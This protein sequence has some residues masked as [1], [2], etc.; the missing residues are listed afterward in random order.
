MKVTIKMQNYLV[1]LLSFLLFLSLTACL[2]A[3]PQGD[4]QVIGNQTSRTGTVTI[5]A[6]LTGSI[7]Y[8]EIIYFSGT[9]ESIPNDSFLLRLTLPD[10]STLVE[11]PVTISNGSWSA[12][13]TH[14]Y[15]GEPTQILIYALPVDATDTS[16]DYALESLV[17]A[18]EEYRPEGVFAALLSPS[19]DAVVG[20]DELEIIGTA[21]GLFENTLLIRLE[22]RDGTLISET[23]I[24]VTNPNFIDE[25]LWSADLPTNDFT[26]L[27]RVRLVITDAR[28]GAEITLAE[29]DITVSSIA[30]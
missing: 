26:G 4:L 16:V 11:S 29:A 12:E 24:T 25:M 23:V 19:P 15:A 27:A 9:A 2:G 20:G 22:E 1:R 5:A 21:S 17:I 18:S 8:S 3:P 28:D 10:D 14:T 7:I 6:P 13:V 30:G